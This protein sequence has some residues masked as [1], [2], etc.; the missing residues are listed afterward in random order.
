MSNALQLFID[1]SWV[2]YSFPKWVSISSTANGMIRKIIRFQYWVLIDE[3][4]LILPYRPHEHSKFF[5]MLLHY[6]VAKVGWFYACGWCE[7]AINLHIHRKGIYK[8]KK[9][10]KRHLQ[11]F[12]SV[13]LIAAHGRPIIWRSAWLL[14]RLQFPYSYHH[15][16]VW[17]L[18]SFSME[19]STNRAVPFSRVSLLYCNLWWF[20]YKCQ[21]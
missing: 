21:I 13:I 3:S 2:K 4:V 19:R 14:L 16:M 10:S 1:F 6:M 15:I 12:Y 17:K 18:R 9:S 20:Q 7:L 5:G 8:S 11:R